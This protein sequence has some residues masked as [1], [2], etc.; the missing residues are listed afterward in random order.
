[1]RVEN[2]DIGYSPRPWQ[3]QIHAELARFSVLVVHRRGGKTVL[4]VNSLIHA[5][6]NDQTGVGR[7]AYVAP[8]LK[9]SKAVAWDYFRQ[10]AGKVPGV[11]FRESEL[12][13]DF[14]NGS[15]IRL[16][17]ADNPDSL[18]GIK[19]SG[20]CVDEVAQCPPEL[21]GEVLR[22]ALADLAP[23][24]WALF[25][26]TPKGVNLFSELYQSAITDESGNWYAAMWDVDRTGVIDPIEL[27]DARRTMSDAQYR[28]EFLCDFSASQDNTLITID[29]VSEAVQRHI[30]DEAWLEGLPKVIGVDVARF[31]DD[32]SVIQKRWGHHAYEPGVHT[33][34]DN[35]ALV[36]LVAQEF[37]EFK[38]DALFVDGGRGEGVIDRLR[39]LGY[40]VI[41]V[42]FGAR[43]SNDA[44]FTNKRSEM[45][46]GMRAWLE[47][48]GCLPNNRHLKQDLNTPTYSFDQSN[49]MVL[50]KKESIKKRGLP[51]PDLGDAL[52][53]TF[54]F[55]V[56][57]KPKFDGPQP[58]AST[59]LKHE[60]DPYAE[61]TIGGIQ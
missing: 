21:W 27:E 6:L 28:Q 31:G 13:V 61:S 49:R 14:P 47:A 53:L 51:S 22:P 40:P 46:D 43:A 25:I 58:A 17:G 60:Y 41:E 29:I 56:R 44:H 35:M 12:R 34:I 18:R 7:Y 23:A 19:L 36:G 8:L 54:A 39:Q 42:Q 16:Y 5:A 3:M 52:A 33:K 50:E 55:P 37:N 15:R 24:S 30:N 26:G 48:G 10:F 2:I 38:P 11:V 32:R 57:V 9:M 59:Q 4:A 1:M 45:W 20:V